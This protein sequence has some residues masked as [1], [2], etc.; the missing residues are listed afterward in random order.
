MNSFYMKLY[1]KILLVIFAVLFSGC[2]KKDK[3]AVPKLSKEQTSKIKNVKLEVYRYEKDLFALDVNRLPDGIAKLYGKYPENLIAKDS[4]KNEQMM[5]GLKGYLTDPTIKA[6]YKEVSKQYSSM[7]DIIKEL[8]DAFKIYLKHFP[9]DAVPKIYT[10]VPGMNFEMPSVFGYDNDIFICIDMY[11][12]KDFKYYAYAGMPKF[13]SERCERKYMATD[14][15]TK[16][17][18]YKHLPEKTLITSLDNMIF[19]GKKLFVT[20]TCFPDKKEQDILG[21]SDAKYEWA[22]KYQQQVW[23]YLVEKNMLYSKDEDVVRRLVDETPFT[24]DFG[25][26]SPGRLGA[27]LGLQIVKSFMRNH[28]EITL[29]NLLQMT[30]SQKLLNDSYY[31]P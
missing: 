7:D 22:V 27:Y 3:V 20:Q 25:N 23:Q 30:D 8:Q 18:A 26:Q 31:K 2:H 9:N 16:G 4:W 28:S 19:E 14:C 15:F 12:G 24:R 5:A 13:I 6:V 17:L 10:L 11:L 21:Y 29:Q 1:F